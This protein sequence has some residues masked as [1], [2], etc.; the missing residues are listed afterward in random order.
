MI[1]SQLIIPLFSGNEAASVGRYSYLGNSVLEIAQNLILKPGIVLQQLLSIDNLFYLILLFLPVAWGISFSRLTPLIPAIPCIALNLLADYP[2]QKDL[3]HQYSVPALP[4]I[5]LAVISTLAVGKGWL[6]QPRKIVLWSLIAFL[7]LAKYGYLWSNYL[8]SVDN[9]VATRE[10]V[11]QVRN[12]GGVLTTAEISPHL[13]HRQLIEFTKV[14]EPP[15]D[16]DKY[17][18]I[19]L[20][21]RHPG[22]LSNQNFVTDL[23]NKLKQNQSFNLQYQR[24][25]IYLFIKQ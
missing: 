21:L 11:A 17:D 7:A 2:P 14:D 12:K 16:L 3:V 19:L 25:D 24:D 20:N 13:T 22:W 8:S 5:I 1:S 15:A 23:I 6:K 9:W 10:A 18:Y 4:F